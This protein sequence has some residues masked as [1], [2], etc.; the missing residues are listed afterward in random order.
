MNR[1]SEWI[2]QGIAPS[3]YKTDTFND[4]PSDG[5][6]RLYNNLWGALTDTHMTKHDN[7]HYVITGSML[8]DQEKFNSFIDAPAWCSCN[9]KQASG[10]N[11]LGELF[12]MHS[13]VGKHT[14]QN[15]DAVYELIRV[16]SSEK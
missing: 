7:G 13:L 1:F 8:R 4:R 6:C 12:A 5:L 3:P 9:F 10:V 14:I 11:T 16:I 2:K 15:N